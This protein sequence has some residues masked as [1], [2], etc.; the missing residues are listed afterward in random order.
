MDFKVLLSR[1]TRENSSKII[2]VKSI[3]DKKLKSLGVPLDSVLDASKVIFNFPN[4]VLS[5]EEEEI[6]KLGL[7]FGFSIGKVRFVEKFIQ[8]LS[9][10][11]PYV[12]NHVQV[13]EI[14]GYFLWSITYK[15]VRHFPAF[16]YFQM[17][18]AYMNYFS[19]CV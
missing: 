4:R 16:Y 2:R 12:V 3:H 1:L 7:Q 10:L 9:K 6:L 17:P 19:V 11:N 15:Y 8:Q 18:S 5:K 13:R 14:G